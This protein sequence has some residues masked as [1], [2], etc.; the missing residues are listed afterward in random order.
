MDADG[1]TAGGD[2]P[3]VLSAVDRILDKKKF[4]QYVESTCEQFYADEVGRPELAPGIY[5]RLLIVGYFKGI[6]S[7]RGIAWRANDSLSIRSFV[8]I[9][10]L[11]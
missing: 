7:E 6:D 1:S 10:L 2:E 8:R 4:D 11:V 9:A 3:S 5:F